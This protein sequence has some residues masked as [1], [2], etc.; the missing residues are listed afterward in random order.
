MELVILMVIFSYAFGWNKIINV[1]EDT[2]EIHLD[3][4]LTNNEES[5][6]PF[7]L[8]VDSK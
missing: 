6:P 3:I 7:H 1:P 8:T 2:K 5:S 4:H